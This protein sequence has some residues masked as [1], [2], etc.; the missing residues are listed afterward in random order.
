MS[1]PSDKTLYNN[2]VLGWLIKQ[3]KN[4]SYFYEIILRFFDSL[5]II[6]GK[7]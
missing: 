3:Y 6:Q 2:K 1:E 4:D 5:L 7:Y